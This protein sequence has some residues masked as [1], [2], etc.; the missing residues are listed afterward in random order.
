[1]RFVPDG[2][3]VPN[4]LVRAWRQGKVLFLAGAGVSEP[5]D[6]P[7][8]VGSYLRSTEKLVTV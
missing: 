3:I 6:C 7:S 5:Q 4:D 8:F 2:P 1:M